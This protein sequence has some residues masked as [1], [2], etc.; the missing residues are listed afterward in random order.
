MGRVIFI[1]SVISYSPPAIWGVS[2]PILIWLLAETG[3]P[4]SLKFS[5]CWCFHLVRK[6]DLVWP[7]NSYFV[8]FFNKENVPRVLS[9]MEEEYPWILPQWSAATVDFKLLF[10]CGW[11]TKIWFYADSSHSFAVWPKYLLCWEGK[12]STA[13][14][15]ALSFVLKQRIEKVL[16]PPAL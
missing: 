13:L 12:E 15:E 2:P 14:P 7:V 4:K 6:S 11:D 16:F 3:Q 1:S 10:M 8:P 5:I 9:C